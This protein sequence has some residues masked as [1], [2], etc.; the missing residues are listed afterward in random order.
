MQSS[1]LYVNK[2]DVWN[3]RGIAASCV[4]GICTVA[5]L[6]L[7]GCGKNDDVVRYQRLSE[8]APSIEWEMHI[9]EENLRIAGLEGEYDILFLTDTHIV[10]QD[11]SDPDMVAEASPERYDMFQN[12]EGISSAEQ[13]ADW[14]EYANYL[15]VDIV[16][17]GGDIIDYPT[18]A[19]ISYLQEQLE[20]L[21]MP[22]LYTLGNHDWTFPWEYMTDECKE[23]Y[24]PLLEPYMEGNTAIHYWENEELLII[25]VDD[26]PGQVNKAAMDTYEQL[27]DSGKPVIVMVHVPFLTQSVLTYAKEVW[28]SGVVIGGGNYG[29]IY[30][31]KRSEKFL[32]LTTDENSPVELMLAGHVHFYDRDYIDGEKQ[33]L[34]IV[35]DAGYCGGA[36]LLHISGEK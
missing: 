14:V 20:S 27:L 10:I 16:L 24:I 15:D 30:P 6:F 11:E 1:M 19:N 5:A 18:E 4:I 34:Q 36:V 9:K 31:D 2:G 33:L 13:F 25:A 32:E 21:E 12:E 29:G 35:G 17:L 22:Y 8:E 23:T 28:D 7:N 3:M 26:S